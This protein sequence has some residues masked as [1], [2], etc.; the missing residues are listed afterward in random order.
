M[1]D[2]QE[3]CAIVICRYQPRNITMALGLFGEKMVRAFE[4][5]LFQ[6]AA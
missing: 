5:E 4:S 3:L 6:A 2:W 1:D